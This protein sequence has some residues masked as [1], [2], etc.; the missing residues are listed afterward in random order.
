MPLPVWSG[1]I[2][3]DQFL[4]GWLN[5]FVNKSRG[6]DNSQICPTLV[7]FDSPNN[8]HRIP[9]NSWEYIPNLLIDALIS[10]VA[11]H[12]SVRAQPQTVPSRG[13]GLKL[14]TSRSR[15]SPN[16]CHQIGGS[17]H[18]LDRHVYQHRHRA[19]QGLN[20]HLRDTNNQLTDLTLICVMTMMLAEVSGSCI[21]DNYPFHLPLSEDALTICSDPAISIWVLAD[22]S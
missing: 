7:P 3:L 1:Q 2:K 18:L 12:K 16:Y 19:I 15:C 9:L 17:S 20:N 13:T 11:T 10:I 6:Q 8:P 22:P 21:Y 14:T 5:H 4:L